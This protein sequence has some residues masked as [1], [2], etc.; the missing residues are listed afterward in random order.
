MFLDGRGVA[1][2]S[3]LR[4]DVCILGAGAAGI[5]I[6]R[7]LAGR[8]IRVLV[9]ESGG[10]A[11][12]SS[13]QDLA[14]GEV[15]GH[16]YPALESARVRAFGGST[17]HWN[18]WC[19]PF[20]AVDFEERPGIPHS[21]WPI[22]LAE[23]VPYYARAQPL[24]QLGP[25]EYDGGHWA[26]ET[27]SRRLQ[28]GGESFETSIF[29]FSPPTRF[30]AVY[31]RELAAARNVRVLLHSNVTLIV[32]DEARRRV[33]RLEV[34]TLTGRRFEVRARRY[35]LACGGI[36]NARLLL[37]SGV[38]GPAVGRFFADHPH[39]PVGLAV[40]PA[41]VAPFYD[42]VV[43]AGSTR[44]RAALATTPSLARTGALLRASMT[45]E[46]LETDPYID[47][48]DERE[49]R[50]AA[51][52]RD[53][54]SVAASLEEAPLRVYALYMRSE[55]APNPASRV[56]LADER[57]ALGMRRARLEWRLSDLD[58]GSTKRMVRLLAETVGRFGIGRVFSRPASDAGFWDRVGAGFHHMGTTRMGTDPRTAVVDR[59]CRMLGV[60][61][62]SVAGSSVFAT[63][64]YSNPTLT[65]V[66][67]ALRLADRLARE[68]A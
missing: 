50:L 16:P 23:L 65:I 48:H 56:S 18:G 19:R 11:F 33:D 66:A 21:G 37:A 38:G 40:L 53:V 44:V 64:G 61:N 63:S 2:R 6:A 10:L 52:G 25:Y 67:L 60:E 54:A 24:C 28:L 14:A 57:D 47:H 35:V 30:G 15:A 41:E 36:E 4:A 20:D 51:F 12:E 13:T 31:R 49:Q 46:P 5:T 55:Q 17:A 8:G 3:V 39:S 34:A 32:P 29:Q 26:R 22:T 42:G 62:L 1:D 45:F 27:G 58:R 59:D 9:L 43:S 7:E 68:P